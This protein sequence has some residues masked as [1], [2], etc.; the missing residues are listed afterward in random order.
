MGQGERDLSPFR[1]YETQLGGFG[2]LD[3]LNLF[4]DAAL[5]LI[6]TP[7]HGVA[8]SV[9]LFEQPGF[10]GRAAYEDLTYD[11]SWRWK[12][13]DRNV[14]VA[15]GRAYNTDFHQPTVRN[16][17]V[18]TCGLALAHDFTPRLRGRS[19]SPTRRASAWS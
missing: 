15:S 13:T 12:A 5:N 14:L 19:R 17:W 4:V 11:L 2:D 18:V 6:V 10:L 8:A 9:K 7:S 16:D 1:R 3:E